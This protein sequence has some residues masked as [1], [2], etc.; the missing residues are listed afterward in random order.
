MIN[1]QLPNRRKFK[2]K[3]QI[4]Q[5]RIREGNVITFTESGRKSD[6][7]KKIWLFIS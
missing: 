4:G 2:R 7:N 1:F 5:A 6:N 3:V